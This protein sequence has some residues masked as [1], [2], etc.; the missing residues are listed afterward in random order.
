[1]KNCMRNK[2]SRAARLCTAGC[3]VGLIVFKQR[4]GLIG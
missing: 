3:T 2:M 4:E 1:M